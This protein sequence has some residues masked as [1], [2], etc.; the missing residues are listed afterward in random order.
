MFIGDKITITFNRNG[1][2]LSLNHKRQENRF[3]LKA[4]LI[5]KSEN[6]ENAFDFDEINEF[7]SYVIYDY[8]K[9]TGEVIP[10]SYWDDYAYYSFIKDTGLKCSLNI[11]DSNADYKATV[12]FSMAYGVIK[13][14]QGDFESFENVKAGDIVYME[15]AAYFTGFVYGFNPI[16]EYSQDILNVENYD[17][18]PDVLP[19]FVNELRY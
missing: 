19:L 6:E 3:F 13:N 18:D 8:N 12:D 10:Q 7:G 4:C 14:P 15:H 2:I 9:N 1:K 16:A 5:E 11:N 17:F